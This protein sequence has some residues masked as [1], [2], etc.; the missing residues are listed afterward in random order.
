MPTERIAAVNNVIR[1]ILCSGRV[2]DAYGRTYDATSAVARDTGGI[3]YD[4]VRRFKPQRTLEVGMAYGMST[5]F[6]SQALHDNGSGRHTAIDPLE[7]SE[8][9]SIGLL[10]L[11]RAGLRDLVELELAPSDAV[12]P[13]FAAENR[14]FDF[15]FID[16]WHLFDFTLVDFYYVDKVLDVGGHVAFDD[17]WMPGIRKVVSFVM[18]NKPYELVRVPSPYRVPTWRRWGR[19]AR[20]FAQDPLGGDWAVKCLPDNVAVLRKTADDRR[21]W[22]YHRPF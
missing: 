4:A 11:E 18:R 22:D 7:N 6:I 19:V 20:R 15:A 10:N 2:E 9:K 5:L 16:G 3:L 12:L 13:R 8:F 1:Q 17:L 14:R 21:T